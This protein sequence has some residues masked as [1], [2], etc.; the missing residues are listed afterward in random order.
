MMKKHNGIGLILLTALFGTVLIFSSGCSKEEESLKIVIEDSPGTET[1]ASK[2]SPGG[3]TSDL[4]PEPKH[5]PPPGEAG[6]PTA[7]VGGDFAGSTPD[8]L[9]EIGPGAETPPVVEGSGVALTMNVLDV[10]KKATED[11]YFKE[12]AAAV[13]VRVMIFGRPIP[14]LL[15]V[16]R[17]RNRQPFRQRSRGANERQTGTRCSNWQDV[18]HR[19]PGEAQHG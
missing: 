3:N 12:I 19:R 13:P 8:T 11:E 4:P 17:S 7:R 5:Y 18:S 16:R 9:P 1:P 2:D 15:R 6:V 10:M 14:L